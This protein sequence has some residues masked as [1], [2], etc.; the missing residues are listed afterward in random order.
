MSLINDKYE[1]INSKHKPIQKFSSFAF[2]RTI[3]Y[4]SKVSKA[5][6]YHE[7]ICYWSFEYWQSHNNKVLIILFN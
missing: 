3:S 1:Q 2:N 4:G 7:A 6:I 5:C